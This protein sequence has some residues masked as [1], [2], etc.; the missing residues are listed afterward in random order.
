M[1]LKHN[2]RTATRGVAPKVRQAIRERNRARKII[3]HKTPTQEEKKEYKRL[4]KKVKT[5]FMEDRGE[6]LQRKRN[7]EGMQKGTAK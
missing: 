1:K 2:K 7:E 5:L 6:K 4:Q 3:T